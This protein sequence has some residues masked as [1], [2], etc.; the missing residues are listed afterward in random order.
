MDSTYTVRSLTRVDELTQLL[1][2]QDITNDRFDEH[3]SL[4]MLIDL[5]RNGGHVIGGF[6]GQ[7]LIGFLVAFM[8]TDSRDP[9]RP[10]MANLKLALNRIV[11]HP[12]YR[13]VGVATQMA[14]RLWEIANNQGIRLLTYAF[15][16][17]R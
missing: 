6:D 2:L 3:L 5:V 10:A 13:S 1:D 8:G 17:L 11:V 4:T 7:F 12:D 15:H 9:H 16:P 14:L